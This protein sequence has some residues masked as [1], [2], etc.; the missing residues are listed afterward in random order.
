MGMNWVVPS[1]N[2]PMAVARGS[3][4]R[5]TR[6]TAA[7]LLRHHRNTFHRYVG[8]HWPEDDE[9]RVRSELWQWLETAYY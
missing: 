8:D 3:S 5:T 4:P 6:S 7:T 1:P 2:D 9:R